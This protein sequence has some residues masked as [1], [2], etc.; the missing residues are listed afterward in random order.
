MGNR[1]IYKPDAPR[2]SSNRTKKT[3]NNLESNANEETTNPNKNNQFNNYLNMFIRVLIFFIIIL[4]V[5][6]LGYF[7]GQYFY[8]QK[9]KPQ[10]ITQSSLIAPLI[11]EKKNIIDNNNENPNEYVLIPKINDKKTD[12]KNLNKPK[13][14][15]TT[16]TTSTTQTTTQS[17]TSTNSELSSNNTKET[18]I[19]NLIESTDKNLN[20]S[21]ENKEK[22]KINEKDINDNN[23]NNKDFVPDTEGSYYVQV[24]LFSVYNNA[25]YVN[26]ILKNKG[27]YSSIDEVIIKNTK[28]YRVIV[29]PFK[30]IDKANKISKIIEKEGFNPIVRKF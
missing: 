5:V 24:G 6:L 7:A 16:K 20:S 8:S 30:N 17:T 22:E 18:K 19:E 29:G 11:D 4:V 23:V 2:K 27:I 25:Q 10:K 15:D 3:R 13:S 9:I 21:D 14:I 12:S 1:Y 28:M 26:D